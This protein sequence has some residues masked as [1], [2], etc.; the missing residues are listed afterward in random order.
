M[1]RIQIFSQ[2]PSSNRA[3]GTTNPRNTLVL[4]MEPLQ[5]D[6]FRFTSR[7]FRRSD[8]RLIAG[9]GLPDGMLRDQWGIGNRESRHR[10]ERVLST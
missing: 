9:S 7:R 4:R 5:E 3:A 2:R 8:K 10:L 6:G 1:D